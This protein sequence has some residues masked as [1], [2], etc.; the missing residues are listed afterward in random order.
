M[1][2]GNAGVHMPHAMSYPIAGMVKDYVPAGFP[3][4]KVQDVE[5]SAEVL[6]GLIHARYI[7]SPRG[8]GRM[9]PGRAAARTVRSRLDRKSDCEKGRTPGETG[10]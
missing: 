9:L 7:L 1:G 6:Y 10:H 2:F 5:H 8:L 3:D 4:D